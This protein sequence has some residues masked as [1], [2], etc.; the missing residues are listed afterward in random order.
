[1]S[2][3][4]AFRRFTDPDGHTGPFLVIIHKSETHS[5]KATRHLQTNG[6]DSAARIA[7]Y[8]LHIYSNISRLVD[9]VPL[10]PAG[11]PWNLD[12]NSGSVYEDGKGACPVSD[13]LFARSILVPIPSNLS[14]SRK[15]GC[16][17]DT[18]SY[19]VIKNLPQ[20]R[21]DAK[22][23]CRNDARRDDVMMPQST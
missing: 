8:G 6:I 15:S 21:E 2:P 22:L 7:D 11:N 10:S 19:G 14:E 17:I 18:R 4:V 23:R 16:R 12:A 3:G 5:V 20:R 9:K 13:A 1:M